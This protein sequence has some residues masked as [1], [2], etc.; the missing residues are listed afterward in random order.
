MLITNVYQMEVL[1]RR[2][3]NRLEIM[4]SPQTVYF[5]NINKDIYSTRQ[6]ET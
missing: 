2:R 1:D 5:E 4:Q 6:Y 3:A